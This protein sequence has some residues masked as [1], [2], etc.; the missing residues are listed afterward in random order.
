[1]TP[2]F[3]WRRQPFACC[4]VNNAAQFHVLLRVEDVIFAC[5]EDDGEG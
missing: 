2:F 4:M 1:M 3:Q 5:M